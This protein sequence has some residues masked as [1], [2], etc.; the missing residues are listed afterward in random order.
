M[1]A[2][3]LLD[4]DVVSEPLRP[5]PNDKILA[6]LKRHQDELAIASIVWHELWFGCY[7]LPRSAKR[8]AIERYLTEVVALSM[9]IVPYDERAAAWH[10]AER[11]RLATAGKPPPFADGQ[12]I[13]I[14]QVNSLSLVTLNASDYTN[15][16]GVKFEDW[17][18]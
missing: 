10:A 7:R 14:A 4:T 11:A 2:K 3:Y 17:R 15:F 18:A 13:A 12:I 16:Q 6:R 8:V 5:A 9:P 1:S